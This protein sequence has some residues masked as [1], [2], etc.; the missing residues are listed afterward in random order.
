MKRGRTYVVFILDRSG[1]MPKLETVKGYNKQVV[2]LLEEA[3]NPDKG[4]TF[5][6]LVTFATKVTDEFF[7]VPI[8]ILREMHPSQ[9][10]PSGWTA[11]YDAIGYSIDKLCKI[12]DINDE[13][14]SY[15]I[16]IISDGENNRSRFWT[17]ERLAAKI[18]ELNNTNR[19]TFTY[20]GANQD[21]SKVRSSLNL[22]SGNTQSYDSSGRGTEAAF[23]SNAT[24]MKKWF[25]NKNSS[26]KGYSSENYFEDQTPT[27]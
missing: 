17:E 26:L 12:T 9:Y 3:E 5:A 7:N 15:L 24:Q 19:W 25:K 10:N 6:S 13:Y 21:L 27:T 23:A 20:I 14:N 22:K 2:E 11:L 1:S 8:E 4:E 16:T 18:N